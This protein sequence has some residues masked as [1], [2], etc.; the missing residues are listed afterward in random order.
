MKYNFKTKVFTDLMVL[1]PYDLMAL[2][3]YDVWKKIN[4]HKTLHLTKPSKLKIKV[5][6][7]FFDCFNLDPIAVNVV[8]GKT[9]GDC[10]LHGM[11]FP[12]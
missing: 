1:M 11:T 6:L 3:P 7:K 4:F 2:M 9:Y 8:R 10:W 5:I 12:V